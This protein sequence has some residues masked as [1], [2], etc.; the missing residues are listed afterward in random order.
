M[1]FYFFEGGGGG[2]RG[3]GIRTVNLHA[4]TLFDAMDIVHFIVCF[5]CLGGFNKNGQA[6]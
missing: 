3:S 4:I 6:S 2:G 5:C 1:A